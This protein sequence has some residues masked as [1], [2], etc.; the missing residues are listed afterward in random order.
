MPAEGKNYREAQEIM[1]G[2]T[3]RAKNGSWVQ[4]CESEEQGDIVQFFDEDG[5]F[6]RSV[7]KDK[8]LE[9]QS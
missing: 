5:A 2:D 3:I 7:Y 8:V 6:I 4:I 9:V 1:P